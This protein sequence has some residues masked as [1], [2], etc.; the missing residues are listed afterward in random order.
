MLFR[1]VL[2]LFTANL[3][4]QVRI[5][6]WRALTCPLDIR[7][8]AIVSD[9][10]YCATGGGLLI[11]TGNQFA[12]LT[13]IDGLNGVDISVIA[14]DG[15]GY[16]WLGGNTPNG[17]IQIYDPIKKNSVSLFDYGLTEIT[18]FWI[19]DS[20]AFAAFIQ[21]QDVGLL[22]WLFVDGGWSYR[23]I[24]RNFPVNISNITGF[25]IHESMV[26]LGSENG[27][28]MGRITNNLKDPANWEM[29]FPELS[30]SVSAI[31]FS[32][33]SVTLCHEGDLYE[34]NYDD[35]SDLSQQ[36]MSAPIEF[37]YLAFDS[38]DFLWGIKGKKVY[39]KDVSFESL[40]YR[41]NLQSM[42]FAADGVIIA[43]SIIGLVNI[44]TVNWVLDPV[45][46]NAPRTG[47]FSAITVL[48]DGRLVG[49]SA[50]GL[51]VLEEDGWRNILEILGE[52]TQVVH[53][54]YDYNSF[55]ADTVEY[56]FGGY[57]ADIEE[58]PDGKI[59]CGIRGVYPE[60]FNPYK[61]GGGV[62]I[63]DIDN[64]ED[65]IAIDT[66]ILG[67]HTT[68]SNSTPYMVVKDVEFDAAGN[69]WV[70]NPYVINKNIPI[71]VRNPAGEWRSYGSAETSVKI[72]QSP[73]G[74]TFDRWSRAW[75]CAFMAEEAN[76][77]VY[78]NGGLFMLDFEGTPVNPTDF[79]W[80][81]IISG[82]TTW[83][84]A[85][86]RNDRLYYLTPTGLNYYDIRDGADW[87]IR[88]NLYA[89]FPNI[90][91][92]K[93]AELKVD[94]QGNIWT[95]SP[96][97][98]VHV[99]LENTTYWPDINGLRASNSPLLSDEITDIAFDRQR[100]LAYIA[101]SKGVNILRIPF[102]G[103]VSNYNNIKIFPSPFVIPA[104]RPMAVGG[105]LYDSSMKVMTL[106]GHVIRDIPSRGI[107]VDG[108]QLTWD[109]KDS[110]GSYVSSGVY[111][112]AIYST[113]GKNTFGKVTVIRQ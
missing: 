44:D 79:T 6:D 112:L 89:Y 2:F 106:D 9:T 49:A 71:H 102:G 76:L 54:S 95:H 39:R 107:S 91:F 80:E 28:W 43:G 87:F 38:K 22:K 68:Q 1:A 88:E 40:T 98:G 52:N 67:Y 96:S 58:G 61:R 70:V 4:A 103:S 74:I 37:E 12:T 94:P 59:Y 53:S 7:D 45:I 105:L 26:F 8:I 111:L 3:F 57:V 90:S 36:S 63:I 109:G 75:V 84:V 24:F 42:A 78:P 72:S 92:G 46:P 73:N 35:L 20:L 5:G 100:G 62:L 83:S 14:A 97:Q 104:D 47:N 110:E 50:W 19:D 66:T 27:L 31:A 15:D 55:I 33:S 56:D 85:M 30:G 99:L 23:D 60:K 108:D 29:P 113:S 32:E 81:K 101:T 41:Y 65:I 82:E 13:T 64:P 16:L 77:G 17:F 11:K 86:G 51:S 48:G 34:F 93:G 18:G 21:G 10:M 25:G 69:L